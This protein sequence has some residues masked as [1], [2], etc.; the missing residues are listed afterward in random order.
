MNAIFI[1]SALIQVSAV[2]AQSGLVADYR[3]DEGSGDRLNDRSNHANHGTIHGAQWVTVGGKRA[4]KFDGV[5][6]HVDCGTGP[7]L[8]LTGPLSLE[9]WFRAT[10]R[11]A[12]EVGLC[13]KF[14]SSFAL[15]YYKDNHCWWYVNAGGNGTRAPVDVAVWQYVVATFDGKML[16]IHV[17]G[18]LKAGAESKYKTTNSGKN[19]FIGKILADPDADDPAY[20][21]VRPFPGLIGTVRVHNRALT[22]DEIV[23]GYRREAALYGLETVWFD[24]TK[25]TAYPYH[26][27]GE[28]VVDVDYR[29]IVPLPK[30]ARMKVEL[31]A[32]DAQAPLVSRELT[33]LPPW[34]TRED[35]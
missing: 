18:R 23:A 9:V 4:L 25:L 35:V 17:N 14:Y 34:G 30:D 32:A 13:G 7:T 6:D 27:R 5:D 10:T 15:T 20:G 16:K 12:G 21:R 2:P 1:V 26:D 29:G 19:F 3:F 22:D 33:N 28:I 31:A 8:D 24:R 11:V